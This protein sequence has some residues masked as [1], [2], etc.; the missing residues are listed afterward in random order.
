MKDEVRPLIE[1]A[2]KDYTQK[3]GNWPQRTEACEKSS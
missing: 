3:A 2:A 1:A